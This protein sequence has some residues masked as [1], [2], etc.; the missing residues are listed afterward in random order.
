MALVKQNK[1]YNTF[2][3]GLITEANVLAFPE[4]ASI[5]EDNMV[6]NIDGSRQRR[7]GI[8]YENDYV[9]VNT[10]I[11]T[12]TGEPSYYSFHRWDN[13][14]NNPNIIIGV[15]HI[16]NK[17][18]FVDMT[19]D[20]LSL[21]LLNN[22]NPITIT[23]SIEPLYT[24]LLN[25]YLVCT[26]K[27]QDPFYLLY[28]STTDT[29]TKTTIDIFV[30]DI[31][32]VEDEL[33][34]TERPSTSTNNHTYNLFNQGWSQE[35]ITLFLGSQGVYP[36]NS[37]IAYLG[38][39]TAGD[40]D[41]A[42]LVKQFFGNTLAPR[43]MAI[44]SYRDRSTTR[45]SATG[46]SGITVDIELG[47]ISC[48]DSYAGRIF[49]SGVESNILVGDSRSPNYSG[50]IFFSKIVSNVED[51]SK[52]Y[53]EADPTS[54]HI[55]DIIDTDG[56]VIIIPEASG[57]RRIET[58]GNSLAVIADNGVWE[59]SGGSGVFTAT[60]YQ[61]RKVTNI[62]VISPNSVINAEGTLLY[63]SI[64]GIYALATDEVSGNLI[65]QNLS[66]TTIQTYYNSIPSLGK[67]NSKGVYDT[68]EKK[69]KWLYNDEADYNL[70]NRTNY[71]RELILDTRLQAFYPNTI[72]RLDTDSPYISGYVISPLFTSQLT[73]ENVVASGIIVQANTED[74]VV[75][76]TLR[77]SS[78]S[79]VKYFVIKPNTGGNIEFTFG[80]YR[81]T[82][83]VDWFNDDSTGVSFE[84]YLVTGY[85]SLQD[86]QRDKMVNYIT[87]HFLRTE[88]GF[89][90]DGD[91][92]IPR[93]QSS[94]KV[95]SRWEWTN[96]ASAGRWGQEF[97][98]YR[99]RLNFIPSSVSDP[100]DYG[101]QVIST[102]NKLR[103]KGKVLSLLIKSEEGKDMHL[104]GWGVDYLGTNAL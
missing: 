90:S 91:A 19:K 4:N 89:I 36:S 45:Q 25:G 10:G 62:G 14:D 37:D 30:R 101:Y 6:L 13:A 61:V 7:L 58:I 68:I 55:S 71:N 100:Y 66:Q 2:V 67:I 8:D 12:I 103:G 18:Y 40:F 3:R 15:V 77:S 97:Q 74:V 28:D 78:Q 95:Q 52:C 42:F 104:L 23:A 35:A 54:E 17:L 39:N 81:N 20:S 94:C 24:S 50:A 31:W 85:E 43:G 29:V 53:S 1:E 5:D 41:G 32:G 65:A 79:V 72:G 93:N 9:L 26:N 27:D 44:I 75:E 47:R 21:N 76:T 98:A 73:D 80:T 49:Y 92:I 84:S 57:I 59:I 34:I 88:D 99:Y 51:F 48:V 83:F 82:D 69:I 87:F 63:W 11:P 22:G 56:G 102:K 86:T 16:Y 33:D 64:G 70:G 38:K 60:N 46:A 96:S